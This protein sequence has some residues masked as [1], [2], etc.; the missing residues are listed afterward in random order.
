MTGYKTESKVSTRTVNYC[1]KGYVLTG[2]E[3]R[4]IRKYYYIFLLSLIFVGCEHGRKNN[5]F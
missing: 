2:D 3:S 5:P 1:C 4:C